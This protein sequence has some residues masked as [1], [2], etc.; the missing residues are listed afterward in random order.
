MSTDLGKSSIKDAAEKVVEQQIPAILNNVKGALEAFEV[1]S[2]GVID[3]PISGLA[4]EF[5]KFHE[6]IVK[7]LAKHDE[8]LAK[9]YGPPKLDAPVVAAVPPANAEVKVDIPPAPG[10]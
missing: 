9:K 4:S 8:H 10:V 1:F 3:H 2:L 5:A 6:L 7:A